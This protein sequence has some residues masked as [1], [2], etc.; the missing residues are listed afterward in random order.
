MNISM[1]SG[2]IGSI[3]VKGLVVAFFSTLLDHLRKE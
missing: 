3:Y 1:V 2:H